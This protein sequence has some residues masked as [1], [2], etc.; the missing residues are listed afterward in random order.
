[1]ELSVI[2]GFGILSLWAGWSQAANLYISIGIAAIL[3]AWFFTSHWSEI[4]TNEYEEAKE[5]IDEKS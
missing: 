3:L 5:M 4:Y 2:G 1:M